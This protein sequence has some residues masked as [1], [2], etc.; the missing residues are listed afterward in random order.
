MTCPDD[1]AQSMRDTGLCIRT[2]TDTPPDMFQVM[3]ERASATNFIRKTIQKNTDLFRTEGLGWKHG[4]PT[5]VAIPQ[6]LL[7]VCAVRNAVD[8]ALSMYTR[9]WHAHPDMQAL[10]FSDFI[11][12]PWNS[13][14]D[15]QDDFEQM[16]AEV[17]TQGVALQLDRDPITGA[18]FPSL[19]ALRR[20]KL[21][22]LM[23]FWARGASV[24][25]VRAEAVQADPEG[26]IDALRA[27]L[28]LPPAR[29]PFNPV[30]RRM[31]NRFMLSVP[32]RAPTPEQM[33]SD[34]MA[35]LRATLDLEQE[36]ALGYHYD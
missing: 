6:N 29:K 5:M 24:A 4:F 9:P 2:V 15:R 13:I 25:F 32:E 26:M 18:M 22:S 10:G 33:S 30:K 23:G 16:H 36:A 8:W 17:R 14:V 35:F 34:D 31:G 21:N 1:F 12:A 7:V 19:F 27:G 11:R 3:G 20:A 28:A